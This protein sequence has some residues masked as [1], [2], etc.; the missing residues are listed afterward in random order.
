MFR[1]LN[2]RTAQHSDVEPIVQGR[3][4]FRMMLYNT[5]FPP[6]EITRYTVCVYPYP[7]SCSL[8]VG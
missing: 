8:H 4:N 7:M 1:S 3:F 2:I 6:Y 5:K